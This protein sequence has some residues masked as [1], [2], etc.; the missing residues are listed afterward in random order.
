MHKPMMKTALLALLS[1]V[2]AAASA[3]AAVTLKD[4]FQQT[5]PLQAG[6]LVTLDNVNGGVTIEAWDKNEVLVIADKEVKAKTD[7]AAKKA[8][9]QVQIQVNKGAGRLDVVTK[10]PKREGGFLEWMTGNNVNINVKYQVKVPRKAA[11]DIETVNGGIRLAGT[12]GKATAETVNGALEI[13]GVHGNLH[14]ET[15]NGAITVARSAGAVDAETTN[16]GIEVELTEVPD[17]S[18]L[19][20]ETT[21]GG[22]TVRLPRD[23]RVS[24]DAATSNGRVDSDFDVDGADGKSRRHLAGDINGGGGKLR[25][26]S[27][28]GSVSIDEI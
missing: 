8:M 10:L 2:F 25:V 23:I 11:L 5:Y 1:L 15:T 19:S 17:G 12:H 14:L 22:V 4:R 7:D 16:G 26:R 13:D 18:D 6:G 9:Q 3:E 24:L 21:N 27:T 28:N 20:F